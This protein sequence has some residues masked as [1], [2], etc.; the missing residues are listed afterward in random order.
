LVGVDKFLALAML[1]LVRVDG[2]AGI[3]QVIKIA[4]GSSEGHVPQIGDLGCRETVLS[5]LDPANDPPLSG[6]LVTAHG[7]FS[8]L[9]GL[10][11]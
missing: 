11:G 10:T 7:L 8:Y 4:I 5:G 1:P 2:K 9:T 6:K 3:L